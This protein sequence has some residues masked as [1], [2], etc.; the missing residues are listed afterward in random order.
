MLM[1]EW[2]GESSSRLPT[3]IAIQNDLKNNEITRKLIEHSEYDVFSSSHIYHWQ[4]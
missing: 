4:K 3:E 2:N 1:P